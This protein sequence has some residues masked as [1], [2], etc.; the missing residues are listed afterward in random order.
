MRF[1]AL[2]VVC[3]AAS[4]AVA[5]PARADVSFVAPVVDDMVFS[6]GC[7]WG[8]EPW[9][10]CGPLVSSPLVVGGAGGVLWR[11]TLRFALPRI[12]GFAAVSGVLAVW[13]TGRCGDP[14]APPV[15]E[16]AAHRTVGPWFA[17]REP[18][19]S[20]QVAGIETIDGSA[21]P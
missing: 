17:Q 5:A 12:D 13:F 20:E 16:I 1:F 2:F 18:V 15:W 19:W 4:L 10:T 3:A 7:D 9:I 14:C 11:S 21:G 6:T 8:Y